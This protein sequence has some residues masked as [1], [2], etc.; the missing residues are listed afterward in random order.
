MQ[1]GSAEPM[2]V[3]STLSTNDQAGDWSW[4]RWRRLGDAWV[5]VANNGANVWGD[6]R[7][8]HSP[9][10]RPGSE[11]SARESFPSVS[12]SSVIRQR[13]LLPRKGTISTQSWRME[14]MECW[15]RWWKPWWAR[16]C[17]KLRDKNVIY[18]FVGVVRA[19]VYILQFQCMCVPKRQ[20]KMWIQYEVM[21][22]IVA[23]TKEGLNTRWSH[24]GR[25][26]SHPVVLLID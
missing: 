9:S 24:F 14:V 8:C 20:S 6:Q 22:E 5:L 17:T 25:F 18:L 16:L 7:L 19:S 13:H 15:L 23:F 11:G 21:G 2:A 26:N 10:K 4:S 3:R 12:F 1:T